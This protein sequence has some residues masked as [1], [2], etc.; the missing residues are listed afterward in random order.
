MFNITGSFTD[1]QASSVRRLALFTAA[2]MMWLLIL[3]V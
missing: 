3:A 2:A 1:L